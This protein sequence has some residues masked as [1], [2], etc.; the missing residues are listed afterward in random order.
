M[1]R[2]QWMLAVTAWALVNVGCGGKS[3][4]PS[5]EAPKTDTGSQAATDTPP[6]EAAVTEFLTAVK[7]GDDERSAQ[8]LTK[9]AREKTAELDLIVAPAGSDTA[10]FK[11]GQ[12]ELVAEDVAHVQCTWTDTGEDGKPRDEQIIWMLRH[13][14]EGWRIAG[15]AT[16]L[17][18][19]E[20]PLLL[21]FENPQDMLEKERMA[22]E[23]IARREQG[24][25]AQASGAATQQPISEASSPRAPESPVRR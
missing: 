14:P 9:L 13:E 16:Q 1:R 20:L 5:T 22:Q 24:A 19:G 17:F 11:V 3:E 8:M 23:E 15:M 18:E 25:T 12:V 6:P 10:T 2:W 7:H 21:D 4:A